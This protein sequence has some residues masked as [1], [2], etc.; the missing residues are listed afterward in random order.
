[1]QVTKRSC[2][3]KAARETTCLVHGA[4]RVHDRPLR[5]SLN[6]DREIACATSITGRSPGAN[7]EARTVVLSDE[8]L[9]EFTRKRVLCKARVVRA[10]ASQSALC[11][12]QPL[13]HER[14]P[15]IRAPVKERSSLDVRQ[16]PAPLQ[17]VFH[18]VAYAVGDYAFVGLVVPAG[19]PKAFA[20]LAVLTRR[21]A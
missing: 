13:R 21:T 5:K 8:L 3:K 15:A 12:H 1:M 6:A 4:M 7:G 10:T 20:E 14:R 9:E 17:I 19:E 18:Y 11:E 2:G 16:R